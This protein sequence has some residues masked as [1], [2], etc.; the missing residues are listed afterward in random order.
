M[1]PSTTNTF[2]EYTQLCKLDIAK[3]LD[4]GTYYV[5]RKGGPLLMKTISAVTSKSVVASIQNAKYLS[6]TCDGCTD[7]TG[8]EYESFY[9]RHASG[10][11][12]YL[13]I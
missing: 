7:F 9:V 5:N 10:D 2:T 1:L 11:I 12:V 3:G 8:D 4:V 13:L 6:F